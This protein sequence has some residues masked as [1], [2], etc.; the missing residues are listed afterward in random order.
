MAAVSN[1]PDDTTRVEFWKLYDGEFIVDAANRALAD[2]QCFHNYVRRA[3]TGSPPT[4]D[5]LRKDC[6]S[7][8]QMW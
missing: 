3:S 1:V 5:L 8:S 7:Q 4:S 6:P 2:Y